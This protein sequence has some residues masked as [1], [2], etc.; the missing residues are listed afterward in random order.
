ML[1]L[2]GA[3]AWC[4]GTIPWEF[5]SL[6]I[7]I[8]KLKALFK[9]YYSWFCVFVFVEIFRAKDLYNQGNADF[10]RDEVRNMIYVV[11]FLQVSI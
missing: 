2:P 8:L 11:Y 4:I 3:H 10:A 9:N 1:F 7:F 6:D 5:I